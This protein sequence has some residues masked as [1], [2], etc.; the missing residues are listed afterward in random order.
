MT[1][2]GSWE[3][4]LFVQMPTAPPC[5]VSCHRIDHVYSQVDGRLAWLLGLFYCHEYHNHDCSH[6]I[7]VGRQTL[8]S[9]AV[10][11]MASS[12]H[13]CDCQ[14]LELS[15]WLLC[16]LQKLLGIGCLSAN[17]AFLSWVVSLWS[18]AD[19]FWTYT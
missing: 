17:V 16:R 2:Q 12:A 13:K 4:Y 11:N 18:H 9:K 15:V 8:T 6:I 5:F 3:T 14:A 7:F 10:D 19:G 1:P